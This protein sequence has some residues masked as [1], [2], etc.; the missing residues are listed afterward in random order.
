[1]IQDLPHLP[2][3]GLGAERL[4]QDRVSRL[5]PRTAQLFGLGADDREARHVEHLR[6]RALAGRASPQFDAVEAWHHDV[7]QQQ[8]G[9]LCASRC[10][11][12]RFFS[13]PGL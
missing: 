9:R 3:Q 1:M 10:D 5:E 8:V 6:I 2:G 12:E 4:G 7:G 11:L 13:V